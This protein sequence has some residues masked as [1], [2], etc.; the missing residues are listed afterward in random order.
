MVFQIAI[1]CDGDVEV[2]RP[3]LEA[4][5]VSMRADPRITD[6]HYHILQAAIEPTP[7]RVAKAYFG[8]TA[9]LLK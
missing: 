1:E 8:R 4:M 3:H 7:R 2:L 6:P 5:L 9:C